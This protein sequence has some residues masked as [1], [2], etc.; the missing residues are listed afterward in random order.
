MSQEWLFQLRINITRQ[1]LCIIK[2]DCSVHSEYNKR[3][4]LMILICCPETWAFS[5]PN[6]SLFGRAP[7]WHFFGVM[8]SNPV[9]R[10]EIS[11][12]DICS[13]QVPIFCFFRL[14]PYLDYC[15]IKVDQER[16]IHRMMIPPIYSLIDMPSSFIQRFRIMDLSWNLRRFCIE[17]R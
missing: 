2:I 1:G 7:S 17:M 3:Y 4:L 6:H 11:N 12:G 10:D 16:S 14:R 8:M 13:F 15:I 5:C 9:D